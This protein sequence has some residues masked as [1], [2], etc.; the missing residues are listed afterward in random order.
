MN[1]M[2]KESLVYSSTPTQIFF[3]LKNKLALFNIRQISHTALSTKSLPIPG[4]VCY[5]IYKVRLAAF[6]RLEIKSVGESGGGETARWS[7]MLEI[8]K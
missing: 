1:I 6:Q 7:A 3:P 8:S 2:L 4:L 5:T